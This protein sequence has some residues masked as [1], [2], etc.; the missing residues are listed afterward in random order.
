[1]TASTGVGSRLVID[2]DRARGGPGRRGWYEVYY[3]TAALPGGRGAWL[4]WTLHAPR[5]GD[6][7]TALWAVAFDTSRP[8]WFAA[9]NQLPGSAWRPLDQGGVALGDA[10]VRPDG[11]RGEAVDTLG[12]T[13]RWE[14]RWSAL[15]APFPFFPAALERTARA[16]TYPIV[17]VPLG[18][19]DGYI[20]I[21]G[22][23]IDCA[24]V[25]VEQ[26]HLFGGHHAHR[27]AWA[28][29][30]GFDE[31]PDGWLAMVWAVPH[32]LGGRLPPVSSLGLRLHGRELRPH[33][34]RGL[35]SVLWSDGGGDV[36]RFSAMLDDVSV[37]AELRIPGE[38]LAGVV[39][40]DPD[41]SKVYC[42]NTEVA[43]CVL[44]LRE[45]DGRATTARCIA[46]CGVER[47]SRQAADGVWPALNS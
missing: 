28:H 41:G 47:G 11:C 32:R 4:R 26:T 25:A 16:A 22:A 10:E 14:L 43:D 7:S 36:A 40:H 20:D 42:A 15:A 31:D 29:A 21:D 12:R 37:E 19:A 39:Y 3:V 27:W 1:M 17:A 46:A 13:M 24:A 2:A 34:V 18:R 5:S 35:R 33:G 9:R 30:L 8:R 45:P 44:R 23:R 38:Q 6:A